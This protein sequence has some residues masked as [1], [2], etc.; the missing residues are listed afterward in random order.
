MNA[1]T[2]YAAIQPGMS[3]APPPPPPA[4]PSPR[5]KIERVKTLSRRALQ[6]WKIAGAILVVG[7]A[8]S[9]FAGMQ[10]KLQYKSECT[11]LY[12]PAIRT[13]DRNDENQSER[14]QRLG[15]KLKDLLVTRTR[16]EGIIK[17]FK[18]YPQI[19][20]SRGAV[21]AVDEMRTHTGFRARDSET[22]VISFEADKPETARQVTEALADSMINE[23]ANSNLSAA[24]QE[25]NFLAKQEERSAA[26]F[27]KANRD[28]ATFLTEHPEFALAAKTTGFAANTSAAPGMS[29]APQGMT[30]PVLPTVTDPQLAVLYR[31]KARL[32]AELRNDI[33]AAADSAA[34]PV[35][36][37]AGVDA[38]TKLTLVRDQAAKTA[39]A[40]ASDLAEKR[41]RLTD[42][43]P[44][45]IT[46]K[47]TAEAAAR[48]LHQA[49]MALAAARAGGTPGANPYDTPTADPAVQ[50]KLNQ[51]NY[52]IAARQAELKH[53]TQ[54]AATTAADADG[55]AAQPTGETNELVQLEATWQ[56]LLG[57]MQSARNEHGDLKQRLEHARLAEGATEA[58]GTDQMT[59]VD[60]AFRPMHPSKG[61]RSKTALMG[62]AVTLIIALAYAFARVIFSDVLI[63][64][65]DIEA[66]N[67]IPVLGVLPKITPSVPPPAPGPPAGTGTL[68]QKGMDR[69]G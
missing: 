48:Q 17:Q 36:V 46:A 52:A 26:D 28:L 64:S 25:V 62:A 66:L 32:E 15:L 50:K 21:E 14:A 39:A 33:A 42:E 54:A 1:P 68:R 4:A 6:H 13:G 9:L 43:H 24:K 11:I 67:S 7:F 35:Q 10:V 61:G 60:P 44:D 40:A 8:L 34:V 47:M 56:R 12:K 55:G 19:V 38:I 65:A 30:L 69:V 29:G 18:L 51:L 53:A 22:Y 58:S 41:T 45:V 3:A 16:L 31:Q 2:P 27:E 63:D 49:D 57:T 20:D 23:F 37:P 59:I 5:E